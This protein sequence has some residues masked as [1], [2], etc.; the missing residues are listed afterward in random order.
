MITQ[1]NVKAYVHRL[2]AEH[3]VTYIKTNL[4]HWAENVTRLSGDDVVFDE[5]EELIVALARKGIISNEDVVPLHVS[6][7]REKLQK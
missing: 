1:T 6:Y 7:L 3:G 2:A 5:T 4:D